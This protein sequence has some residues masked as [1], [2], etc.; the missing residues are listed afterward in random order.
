MSSA[1]HQLGRASCQEMLISIDL[2]RKSCSLTL[3]LN[4]TYESKNFNELK[5][6]SLSLLTEYPSKA[7]D[8]RCALLSCTNLS[9]LN[10]SNQDV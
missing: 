7:G 3:D 9:L 10:R 6:P 8:T 4:E 5:E 2:N 1:P